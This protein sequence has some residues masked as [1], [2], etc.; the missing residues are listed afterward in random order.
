MDQPERSFCRG[1]KRLEP[2][3]EGVTIS[4]VHELLN[5]SPETIQAVFFSSVSNLRFLLFRGVNFDIMLPNDGLSYDHERK[6][7]ILLF[8]AQMEAYL[9]LRFRSGSRSCADW[10]CY[11]VFHEGDAFFTTFPY[12]RKGRGS[13]GS[14]Q[15]NSAR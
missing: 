11:M 4:E 13:S 10:S 1:L 14:A 12:G 5:L 9:D 6:S 3:P 2:E 15:S 7:E 8:A